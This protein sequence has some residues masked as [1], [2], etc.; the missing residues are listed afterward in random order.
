MG[1]DR[2]E[3][4]TDLVD[5]I[6]TALQSAIELAVG[7]ESLVP[8]EEGDTMAPGFRQ[9]AG[10]LTKA[11][12]HLEGEDEVGELVSFLERRAVRRFGEG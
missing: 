2:V 12:C 8:G 5:Q 11:L 1:A 4:M 10:A 3:R 6:E 9:V 7:Y